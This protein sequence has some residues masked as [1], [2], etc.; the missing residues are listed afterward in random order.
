MENKFQVEL[1]NRLTQAPGAP[2][3]EGPVREIMREYISSYTSELMYD[4]LGSIFG[5]AW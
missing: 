5:Y 4:N 2:G 3:F 1:W